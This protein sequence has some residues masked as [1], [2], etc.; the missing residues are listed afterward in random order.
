M[1]LRIFSLAALITAIGLAT[2]AR[3]EN[4]QH[5]RQLLSTKQC[6]Q[7]ELSGIGLF[8]ADLSGVNLSG[9]NL[10]GA[11]LSRANLNGANLSG[12]NLSGATL[13]GAQLAG[14]DLR[15]ANLSGTDLRDAYLF[16]ANLI[17]TNLTVAYLQGALG[18][19]QYAGNQ[20]NFYNWA[21]MEARN[22]NYQ[23]AIDHYNMALRINPTF[24]PAVL[25]R[26]VARYRLGDERG[27]A[28]DANIAGEL[29]KRQ[30]QAQGYEFSQQFIKGMQIAR[31][32]PQ[33]GGGDFLSTLGGIATLLMQFM[34]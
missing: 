12:A 14:A 33:D 22:D 4:L 27:A 13:Y 7:C 19:P 3:A 5:T 28:Q 2:P 30:G 26:G 15:G 11:N 20:D 23:G 1:K 17:G 25:G 8:S 10:V 18:I 34:F 24:A 9:A 16:N 31:E 29:F 21:V 6:P 32:K